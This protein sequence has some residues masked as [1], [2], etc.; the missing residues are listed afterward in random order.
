MRHVSLPPPT[1]PKVTPNAPLT[2][3]LPTDHDLRDS[4]SVTVTHPPSI[5]AHYVSDTVT[6][7]V[8][9]ARR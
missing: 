9:N 8:M 3:S 5:K 4:N 1:F 2:S 7:M 6:K